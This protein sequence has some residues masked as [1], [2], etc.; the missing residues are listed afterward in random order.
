MKVSE[1]MTITK[2]TSDGALYGE[3]DN[4]PYI[5]ECTDANY[6]VYDG[7]SSILFRIRN[8]PQAKLIFTL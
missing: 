3:K 1:K 5:V 8:S 7:F 4:V 6:P 2:R